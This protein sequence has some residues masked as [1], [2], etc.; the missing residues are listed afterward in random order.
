LAETFRP[1]GASQA[2]VAVFSL[3]DGF[4]LLLLE[5]CCR[6]CLC[7]MYNISCYDVFP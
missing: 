7:T 6:I 4:L 1:S 3:N 2:V 5:I